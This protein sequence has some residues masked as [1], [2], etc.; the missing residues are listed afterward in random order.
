M[1]AI[2]YLGPQGTFTHDAASSFFGSEALLDPR[3]TVV[4]VMRSVERGE[5]EYGV[6]PIEN[7]VQG[8][9]TT[10]MDALVFDLDDVRIV[11]EIVL[12]VTFCALR[13]VGARSAPTSIHSHP[14]AIAQCTGYVRRVGVRV[15]ESKSTADA[16]AF[17]AGVDDDGAI[18]IASHRAGETYGLEV[19][20]EAIEDHRGAETRFLVLAKRSA[21]P[22]GRDKST[23]VV[24]PRNQ[25]RGV[26]ASVFATL[27]DQSIDIHSI[28]SRPVRRR[29]GTYSFFFTVAGHLDDAPLFAALS[30]LLDEGHRLKFLGSYRAVRDSM[31]PPRIEEL[32]VHLLSNA[33]ELAALRGR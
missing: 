33:S 32:S 2:T 26:L 7:S 17:V 4:D 15:L 29:L 16:C 11:G 27:A 9:V 13:K 14:H 12:P 3:A 25:N 28:H 22:T 21:P 20:E 31:P 6:V 10:T 24:I 8:E 23:F 5:A 18:A 30:S 1:M 19:V